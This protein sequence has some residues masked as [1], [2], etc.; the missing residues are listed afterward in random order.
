MS[1][2]EAAR[3]KAEIP[4]PLATP[5]ARNPSSTSSGTSYTAAQKREQMNA[6]LQPPPSRA[7]SVEKVDGEEEGLGRARAEFEYKSDEVDDLS[8]DEGEVVLVLEHGEILLFPFVLR[9]T[10]RYGL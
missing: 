7:Y 1:K 9:I 10:N 5:L 3:K 4:I 2:E 8:L 6:P